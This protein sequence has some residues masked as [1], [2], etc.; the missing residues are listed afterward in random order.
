MS[1]CERT[2]Q[3]ALYRFCFSKRHEFIVPNSCV[4]RWE[5]DLVSVT[6]SGFIHEF[7]IKISRSDFFADQKKTDKIDTLLTGQR[8]RGFFAPQRVDAE[9]PNF[10][11]YVVPKDLI[12]LTEIPSY[13]GLIYISEGR[14]SYTYPSVIKDAPRLHK[15]KINEWQRRQLHRALTFRYWRQRLKA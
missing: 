14:D 6:A 15:E 1:W 13:S 12:A 11:W 9:R 5:A 3:N 4:C 7:E 8:D 10:F 2:M